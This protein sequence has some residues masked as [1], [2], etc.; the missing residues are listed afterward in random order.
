MAEA[1][2][3][4]ARD[5]G[6]L[7]MIAAILQDALVPLA[8]MKYLPREQ[9]FALMVNR[10]RW[11]GAPKERVG[12]AGSPSGRRPKSG[13]GKDARF[14]DQDAT[15]FERVHAALVFDK[16]LSV[17]H[18]GMEVAAKGGV[19]A[20]LTLRLD[21]TVVSISFA[22][23]AEIRLE[24]ERLSCHLEDLGEPWPTVWRPQHSESETSGGLP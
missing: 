22:G 9:R 2:K 18:R 16:V 13:S 7:E 15:A 10:F 14:A 6:D 21:D 3:L 4:R 17:K 23:G 11:E 12:N 20:L 5:A 24:V 19:L 8:N 1:L